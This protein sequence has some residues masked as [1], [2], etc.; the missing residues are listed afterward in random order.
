MNV[1]S[2]YLL[3]SIDDDQ[4]GHKNDIS[5]THPDEIEITTSSTDISD[6]NPPS[7]STKISKTS[8]DLFAYVENGQ[9]IASID[10]EALKEVETFSNIDSPNE[11]LPTSVVCR[12]PVCYSIDAAT[13][14]EVLNTKAVDEMSAESASSTVDSSLS[15]T[16]SYLPQKISIIFKPR[17]EG[18]IS[19]DIARF[20]V[21]LRKRQQQSLGS[22]DVVFSE[23]NSIL[24]LVDNVS[25]AFVSSAPNEGRRKGASEIT[26]SVP[27]ES[28]T[29]G[30]YTVG[31]QGHW[32]DERAC[33]ACRDSALVVK[34]KMC[35]CSVCG[36]TSE[37]T[38]SRK[39]TGEPIVYC[40]SCGDMA[41]IGCNA[42]LR[43]RVIHSQTGEDLAIYDSPPP[44]KIL[45][46]PDI[47]EQCKARD[48]SL[49][50]KTAS[51]SSSFPFTSEQSITSLPVVSFEAHGTDSNSWKSRRMTHSEHFVYCESSMS[52]HCNYFCGKCDVQQPKSSKL[53]KQK[54]EFSSSSSSQSGP[55]RRRISGVESGVAVSSVLDE[56]PASVSARK[57]GLIGTG[58]PAGG[59]NAT[60]AVDN[61]ECKPKKDVPGKLGYVNVGALM[62]NRGDASGAGL[63][64]PIVAGMAGT[65]YVLGYWKG[66]SWRWMMR[67]G[68][69]HH[70][71]QSCRQSHARRLRYPLAEA[72]VY[73]RHI[74]HGPIRHGCHDARLCM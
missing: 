13:F 57:R 3:T 41:H 62:I 35:G 9:I 61:L 53:S 40:D 5:M 52:S 60:S 21:L 66:A 30:T 36:K 34:C 49:Q 10:D 20:Y 32:I 27:K 28:A 54:N 24:E 17:F 50:V 59:G 29:A 73:I 58:E 8:V 37:A 22:T 46:F 64:F 48:A 72:R 6:I 71:P 19:K 45:N 33:I 51:S 15:S 31:I 39:E 42:Q 1:T 16:T 14:N 12:W 23:T 43:W 70:S 68:S 11:H 55:K 65:G 44:E 74:V 2:S 38:N 18:Q 4:N 26:F 69:A 7:N 67:H 25:N 47:P 56:D 63:H